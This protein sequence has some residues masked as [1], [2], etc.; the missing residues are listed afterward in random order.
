MGIPIL[1]WQYLYIEAPHR[2]VLPQ[3][4]CKVKHNF[5]NVTDRGNLKPGNLKIAFPSSIPQLKYG[6]CSL[7]L[8]LIQD[9]FAYCTDKNRAGKR[10]RMGDVYASFKELSLCN[11]TNSYPD[12]PV[13]RIHYQNGRIPQFLLDELNVKKVSIYLQILKAD[14]N[15]PVS[16][17]V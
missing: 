11:S 15:C 16:T 12:I 4:H 1:A 14:G 8:H 5:F 10:W 13:V 17:M 9:A 6:K 3:L 7:H 2:S